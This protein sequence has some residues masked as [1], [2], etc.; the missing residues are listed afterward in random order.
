M[1][2]LGYISTKILNISCDYLVVIIE[3]IVNKHFKHLKRPGLPANFIFSDHQQ[4]I[5]FLR[6]KMC[7]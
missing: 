2:Y 1:P 7:T 6:G 4:N 3:S 5:H